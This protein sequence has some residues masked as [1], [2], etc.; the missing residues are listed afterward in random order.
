MRWTLLFAA[1]AAVST[2][3][4][5]G[6]QTDPAAT[7]RPATDGGRS[8]LARDFVQQ[9]SRGRFS[10]AA[11]AFDKN[12]A[13]RLTPEALRVLWRRVG[14]Q[15]GPLRSFGKP[16]LKADQKD[17]VVYIPA[18]FGRGR[19]TF[20]IVFDAENRIWV[21]CMSESPLTGGV[22]QRFDPVSG[23]SGAGGGGGGGAGA[24]KPAEA[25]PP[26]KIA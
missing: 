14:N 19:R 8:V 9:L 24:T 5:L 16:Y 10:D 2:N 17:R 6:A 11:R 21:G 23:G 3:A 1:A 18:E 26:P 25:T 22:L 12:L 7:S 15:S 13:R 4:P 20:K